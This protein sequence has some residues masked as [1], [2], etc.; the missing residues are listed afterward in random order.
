MGTVFCDKCGASLEETARFCRVCGEATPVTEGTT[1]AVTKRF[2]E[3][4]QEWAGTSPVR[5]PT[6][7]PQY[8][9][10]YDSMIP[11]V[12]AQK[13]KS[14]K[15]LV[16]ILASMLAFM[17]IA[18]GGLLAFLNVSSGPPPPPIPD[19][20]TRPP[21]PGGSPEPPPPPTP[22]GIPPV[23]LDPSLYYPG[24][25]VGKQVL[26]G[27][28]GVFTLSSDD[29]VDKVLDWYTSRLNISQRIVKEGKAVLQSGGTTVTIK[30]NGSGSDIAIVNVGGSI[31][32][33]K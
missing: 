16:I 11:Q 25:K 9:Q 8:V 20:A 26:A 14:S 22:P 4:K 32:L 19:R 27:G 33:A 24:A 5:P 30:A 23:G 29:P 2:D 18:L 6:T 28:T 15:K 3:P 10:Q 12:G 21:G 17:I 13:E 7:A 31:P 1:E